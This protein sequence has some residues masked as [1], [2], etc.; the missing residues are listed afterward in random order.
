MSAS[1]GGSLIPATYDCPESSE[2]ERGED[3]N[4]ADTFKSQPLLY[5]RY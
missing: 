4:D 3:E 1:G 5:S 2:Q